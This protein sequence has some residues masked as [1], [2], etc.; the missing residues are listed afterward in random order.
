MDFSFSDRLKF[1]RSK[2]G[3]SQQQLANLVGVSRKQI[4]DYEVG[5][6]KPRQATFIKVLDAL[7][8]DAETFNNS[9]A[10]L[11]TFGDDSDVIFPYG[12]N[13]KVTLPRRLLKNFKI[14]VD[15]CVRETVYGYAMHPTLN[16]CDQII[17]DMNQKNIIDGKIYSFSYGNMSMVRRLYNLPLGGVRIVSD[18]TRE[19]PEVQ[20]TNTEF[21]DLNFVIYGRVVYRQGY[22]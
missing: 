10:I 21:V 11:S 20:L 16:D 6:S 4:S 3:L 5:A 15:T 22:L 17:I 2:K 19:Y 8:L 18:N 14:N 12:N 7:G 1:F 13:L 9:G